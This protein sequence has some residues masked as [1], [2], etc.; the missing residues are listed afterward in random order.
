MINQHTSTDAKHK[1]L[2]QEYYRLEEEQYCLQQQLKIRR[3]SQAHFDNIFAFW[4]ENNVSVPNKLV[5]VPRHMLFPDAAAA[6]KKNN[7]DKL[8]RIESTNSGESTETSLSG[9]SRSS[10]GD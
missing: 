3:A 10:S 9:R 7:I 8:I 5:P 4:Q 2:K 1:A 6:N